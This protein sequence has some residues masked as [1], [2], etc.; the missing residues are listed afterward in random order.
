M[1]D[2]QFRVMSR[3]DVGGTNMPEGRGQIEVG[4]QGVHPGRKLGV[5]QK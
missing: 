1:I 2:P 4:A 5:Q 3:I